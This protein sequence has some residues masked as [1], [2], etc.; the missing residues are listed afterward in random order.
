MSLSTVE[1]RALCGVE[2]RWCVSRRTFR[3][4]WPRLRL[5]DCPKLPSERV[6]RARA[7]Q[8]A[9]QG[10][11]NVH[12]KGEALTEMCALTVEQNEW[13]MSTIDSLALSNRAAHRILRLSRTLADCSGERLIGSGHLAQALRYRPIRK[14]VL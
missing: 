6:E 11:L 9:R 5:L 8:T 12:L 14:A 13:L 3:M 10:C 7:L 2:S 1:T 4:V